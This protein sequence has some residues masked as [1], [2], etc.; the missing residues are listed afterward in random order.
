ML[1]AW[2]LCMALAVHFEAAGDPIDSQFMVTMSVWNRAKGN[3]NRVCDVV[4]AK[5]Q[6]T[7]PEKRMPIPKEDDKH[8][9][10]AIKVA[11]LSEYMSD[12]TGGVDHYHTFQVSP[13]WARSPKLEILGSYGNHIA[14]RERKP[15][16]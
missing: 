6:Y 3:K 4:Y 11:Q 16:K 7:G 8:F 13:A 14:Y 10:H 9:Q 2:V 1:E 12:F 15:A 5:A